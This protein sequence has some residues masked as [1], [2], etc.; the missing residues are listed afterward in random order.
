M[1][2]NSPTRHGLVTGA[3]LLASAIEMMRGYKP[4]VVVFSALIFVV[5]GNGVIYL[6]GSKER[7][8]RK[9]AKQD[10]YAGLR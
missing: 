6:A 3:I 8:M 2:F 4:L 10:Y 7:A 1:N 9:R 5:L